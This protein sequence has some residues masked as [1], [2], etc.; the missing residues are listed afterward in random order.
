M[1]VLVVLYRFDQA[2]LVEAHLSFQLIHDLLIDVLERPLGV[3]RGRL[4]LVKFVP[5][6][7]PYFFHSEP[8]VWVGDKNVPDHVLRFRRQVLRHGVV[9]THNFLIKV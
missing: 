5:R 3:E 1:V 8:F 9:S 2:L 7:V 6:M 4:G